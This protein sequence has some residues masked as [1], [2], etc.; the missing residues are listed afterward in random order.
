MGVHKGEAP[1]L[2]Q[3]QLQGVVECGL[4]GV[5]KVRRMHDEHLHHS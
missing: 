2:R 4:A 5:A 3:R 1:A